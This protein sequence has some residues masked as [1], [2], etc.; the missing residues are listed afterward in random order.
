[1]RSGREVALGL[2]LPLNDC[3]EQLPVPYP[4]S[5]LFELDR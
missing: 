3:G 5:V 2:W 1:M 4:R